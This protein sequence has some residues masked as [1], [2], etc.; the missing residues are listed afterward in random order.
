MG[1]KVVNVVVE[2]VVVVVNKVVT[3]KKE[4]LV[5]VTMAIVGTVMTLEIKVDNSSQITDQ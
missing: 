1:T 5:V 4:S 3:M 2:V